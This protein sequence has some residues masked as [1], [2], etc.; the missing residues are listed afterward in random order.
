[1]LLSPLLK[2]LALRL[3]LVAS[4][5]AL[6][7]CETVSPLASNTGP[8]VAEVE[9]DESGSQAT[10]ISS[11]SDK[12]SRSPNDAENYNTRGAA[13]ARVGRYREAMSD[14]DKAIALNPNHAAALT[15]RGLAHRQSGRNDQALGDF[16]RAI[17]VNP[18]YAAAYLARGN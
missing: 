14:F 3:S 2:P 1:M 4:V 15:N 8:R 13:Y 5:L 18:N 11:L 9:T 17:S 6:A 7:A 16:S 10:N 12:I